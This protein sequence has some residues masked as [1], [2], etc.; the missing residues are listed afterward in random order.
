MRAIGPVRYAIKSQLPDNAHEQLRSVLSRVFSLAADLDFLT[1]L[2]R[3]PNQTKELGG[4]VPIGDTST[5]YSRIDS[6]ATIGEGSTRFSGAASS[7][8]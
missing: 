6:F 4:N 3:E 2:G 5:R 8:P 7:R 1:K